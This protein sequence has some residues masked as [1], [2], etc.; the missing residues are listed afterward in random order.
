M[1]LTGCI[2]GIIVNYADSSLQ[3]F[4]GDGIFY[5]SLAYGGPRGIIQ[6]NTFLPFE[7]PAKAEGV[8]LVT[9]Q[10]DAFIK[11]MTAGGDGGRK[12][13]LCP[14][15]PHPAGH[16]QHALP[17]VRLCKVCQRHRRQALGPRQRRLEP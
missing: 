6:S 3:F 16:T 2:S 8:D 7:P 1:A 10:L 4:T 13:L 12:L 14:V 11:Q 9:P 17:T 15:G 5:T